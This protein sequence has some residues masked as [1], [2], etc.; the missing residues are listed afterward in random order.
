[1][2]AVVDCGY[3]VFEITHFSYS[4]VGFTNCPST[5]PVDNPD[6]QDEPKNE[7]DDNT[8]ANP[9]EN[10]DSKPTENTEIKQVDNPK[11][12]GRLTKGFYCRVISLCLLGF[13]GF[14]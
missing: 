3:L 6:P 1:M 7:P 2:E 11:T 14:L 10:N 12:S 8:G 4:V 5:D 13:T 9:A